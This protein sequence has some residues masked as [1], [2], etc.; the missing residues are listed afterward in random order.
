[1]QIFVDHSNLNSNQWH[2]SRKWSKDTHAF[3]HKLWKNGNASE[4][5]I[6]MQP[7]TRLTT[8][9]QEYDTFWKDVVFGYMLL[10]EKQLGRINSEHNSSYK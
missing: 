2:L 8:D 6:C 7:V 3:F 9:P 5:G 10:N 4:A 1:M